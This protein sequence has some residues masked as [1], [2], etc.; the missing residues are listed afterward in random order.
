MDRTYLDMVDV[1]VNFLLHDDLFTLMV[2]VSVLNKAEVKS[3]FNWYRRG[4]VTLK[5]T[6][7]TAA[8]CL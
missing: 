4:E 2:V 5:L 7:V 3:Q 1:T 6:L 8:T